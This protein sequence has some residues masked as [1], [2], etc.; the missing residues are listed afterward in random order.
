MKWANVLSSAVAPNG[1]V[2]H[3]RSRLLAATHTLRKVLLVVILSQVVSG[4]WKNLGHDWLSEPRLFLFHWSNCLLFLLLGM[5]IDAGAVLWTH[6]ITLQFITCKHV[7]SEVKS[8]N[9][10]YLHYHQPLYHILPPSQNDCPTP[11]SFISQNVFL[12]PTRSGLL[13]KHNHVRPIYPEC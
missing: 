7:S 3:L 10:I 4:R 1:V 6:I 9:V 11:R 12:Y 8:W 5:V 2:A 13:R